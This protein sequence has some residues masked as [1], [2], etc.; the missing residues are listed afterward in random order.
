MNKAVLFA[1]VTTI[2]LAGAVLAPKAVLAY[3]GDPSVHGPNYS[4]ERHQAM[5]QAFANKDYQAWKAQM[6]GRGRVTQVIN[7]D[8]FARFAEAHQLALEGKLTEANQIRAELGLGVHN[9][10]GQGQGYGR[11]R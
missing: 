10:L 6:A 11:N 4:E 3:R 9:G 5:T 2:A 8:N 7:A 1:G